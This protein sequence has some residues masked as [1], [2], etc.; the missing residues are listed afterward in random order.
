MPRELKD[1]TSDAHRAEKKLRMN[2]RNHGLLERANRELEAKAAPYLRKRLRKKTSA[3]STAAE[4][5]HQLPHDRRSQDAPVVDVSGLRT[6]ASTQGGSKRKRDV[7]DDIARR[8]LKPNGGDVHP[9]ASTSA[10]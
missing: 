4:L 10:D 7:I 3:L 1:A 2:L 6:S 5:R 9:T 8:A